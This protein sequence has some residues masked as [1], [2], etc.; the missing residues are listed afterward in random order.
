MS[1]KT[2]ISRTPTAVTYLERDASDA[3]DKHRV[4][5]VYPGENKTL[6][7]NAKIRNSHLMQ[8]GMRKGIMDNQPIEFW[9]RIP[10]MD[11]FMDFKKQHPRV[12]EDIESPDESTRMKGARAMSLLQPRWI[13]FSR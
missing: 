13:V 10:S 9:F 7:D 1:E 2:L 11:R 6:E 3:P 4:M 5:Q 8:K 12:M